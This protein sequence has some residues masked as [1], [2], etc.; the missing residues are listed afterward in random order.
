MKNFQQFYRVILFLIAA[1]LCSTVT[2]SE[3]K[4]ILVLGDSLSAGY[5]MSERQGWVHLLQQRINEQALDFEVVNASVSGATTSAGLRILPSALS[6]HQPTF[7]ILELGGN[8]GLQGKP[9][10]YIKKQLSRL[11]TLSQNSGAKVMITGIR[12]PPNLGSAY[13]EPFFAQ[14]AALAQEFDTALVPFLLE[15]VAENPE[16]MQADG[17]HPKAE[18]QATILENVWQELGKILQEL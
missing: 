8:D 18:A 5:G 2:A 9:L 17:I 15:G 4:K 1:S 10:A 3:S 16:N 6:T 11:I 13:T 14:Y 12:I 7:V